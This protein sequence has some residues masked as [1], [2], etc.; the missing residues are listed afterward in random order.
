MAKRNNRTWHPNFIKYMKFIV[1]HKNYA[2]MPHKF[3]AD[4]KILWVSPSDKIRAEWWD[5]KVKELNCVNRA[6]VARK[7]HPQE[8]KGYKPCQI[9][10]KELSIFYIYPNKNTLKKLNLVTPE[11]QFSPFKED[12][13]AISTTIIEALGDNGFKQLKSIFNI[14]DDC[15]NDKRSIVNF[16]LENRKTRLSPGAMSNPPD[17]LDGFHTYNACCRSLE[18]TGRHASNLARYSQDRRVYENWAEGNWNLSNRLMGEFNKYDLEIE[19]PNCGKLRKMTAD[20]IGPISLGFTHRPNFQPLCR[21]CNS[22]KNNRMTYQD[23]Q[24]LI[25]DEE[26]GETVVSWHSK[27][28]WDQLKFSVKNQNG[29]FILSKLMRLNLHHILILFSKISE[30]GYDKFLSKYLH[31][32]YS[33]VDYKFIGFHPLTGPKEIVEKPLDSKN[34]EKNAKRYVRI[35]FESLEKY[36]N[37]ENRN[38]KIWKSKKVD[39][40]VN[41][42]MEKLSS[43]Q[44]HDATLK[45]NGILKQLAEEAK[46]VFDAS[47]SQNR[48]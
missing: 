18:D 3:G 31:P 48:R 41:V 10:G 4:G 34:K 46:V 36:K 44:I 26:G 7:I 45:M 37:V 5:K 6:E 13:E 39:Q 42:L 8:L 23:I 27:Y 47:I 32:E 12:V 21:A 11:F 1:T 15:K 16:I 25:K 17:R 14:P 35:S 33:F 28:I 9:C 19:C 24:K 20:H 30:A 29:A 22:K 2:D 38:T 43:G 40:Q